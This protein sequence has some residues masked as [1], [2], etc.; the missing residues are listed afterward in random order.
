M[1]F[2]DRKF[3]LFSDHD[4]C[5]F[6]ARRVNTMW[7]WSYTRSLRVGEIFDKP[8]FYIDGPS[9]DDVKQGVLGDCWFLS[10][11]VTVR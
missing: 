6:S 9:P 8:K 3:D 10:A 7:E 2:R 11:L 5:L 4:G 1:R